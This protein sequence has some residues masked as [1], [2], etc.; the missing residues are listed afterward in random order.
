MDEGVGKEVAFM[1]LG[2]MGTP[3]ATNLVKAGYPVTVWNRTMARAESLA[4]I[5]ARV[6]AD[7]KDAVASVEAI[8]LMLESGDSVEH[9]LFEMG[10]V[11]QIRP[12]ATVVDMSS[13]SPGTARDHARRLGERHI[14]Y[15]DAPVSGGTTGA[16]DATLAIMVGGSAH[17]F[18]R[19]LPLLRTL[20]T[21]THLGP[22]GAGQAAK[23]VNQVIVGVSIGAVVEGL[24]LASKL[25]LDLE[26]L[27]P[28]L[29]GGF[30]D[31][32]ILREHGRRIVTSDFHAG[33]AIRIQSKDLDN[34]L[35]AAEEVSL[36]PPISR[37]VADEY[38]DLTD[39][40]L[41]DLDHSALWLWYQRDGD[42]GSRRG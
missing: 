9:V 19:W 20:G 38:S 37:L 21:P 42:V 26:R 39:R 7:P 41:E 12:G 10:T 40:G 30:A 22:S 3:M 4:S 28:A 16:A 29:W 2:A 24:S 11:D 13:I 23:L 14:D 17:V 32:R 6:C 15:L 35:R 1:G 31:S 5:G 25:E 34:A 36:D 18:Q 33:G 27:L 8:I